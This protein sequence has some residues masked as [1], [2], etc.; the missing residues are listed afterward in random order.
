MTILNL[1]APRYILQPIMSYAELQPN[2]GIRGRINR[3]VEWLH[4]HLF[5]F[6]LGSMYS[7]KYYSR[8]NEMIQ[9]PQKE[10]V[11]SSPDILTGYRVEKL[12]KRG[13]SVLVAAD[14]NKYYPTGM[15][16]GL[17]DAGATVLMA[18]TAEF[19]KL[20]TFMISDGQS[21]L[22]WIPAKKL[23]AYLEDSVQLAKKWKADLQ[24]AF[25]C[26]SQIQ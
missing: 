17:K 15:I 12:T 4:W 14:E 16:S 8:F 3:T 21:V 5:H 24:H 13:V 19:N 7:M 11:I 10:L 25:N 1:C 6:E 20:P 18:E 2:T 9:K 26:S 23:Y 22:T